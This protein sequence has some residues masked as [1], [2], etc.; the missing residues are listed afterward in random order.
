MLGLYT[1][2]VNKSGMY[3]DFMK[4]KYPVSQPQH[5]YNK[6]IELLIFQNTN[7]VNKTIARW[8]NKKAKLYLL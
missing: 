6:F 2:L 8:R 5:V 7:L 1:F 4:L 3:T